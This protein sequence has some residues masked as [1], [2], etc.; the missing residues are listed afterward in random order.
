MP[1]NETLPKPSLELSCQGSSVTSSLAVEISGSLNDA[2]SSLSGLP[3]LLSCSPDYG[4][5]WTALTTEIT[6]SSGGFVADWTPQATGTYLID[7]AFMGNDVYSA[8]NTTVNFVLA[9]SKGPNVFS[10]ASNSTLTE[11]AFNSATKQLSFTVSRP[12]GTRGY[13]NISIPKSVV[14]DISS[15][16]V[17]IDSN[18]VANTSQSLPDS[19]LI[20]FNNHHST[21]KVAIS[22]DAS[23]SGSSTSLNI[24]ALFGSP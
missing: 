24:I 6:D 15:L 20:S 13:V 23:A 14:S 4:N 22:L 21:H 11:F 5:S 1:S 8:T 2:N 7:A 9:P 12:T 17:K 19:W 16:Q 18:Q 3:V 10:V